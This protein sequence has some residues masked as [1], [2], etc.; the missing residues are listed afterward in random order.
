MISVITPT[1]D[2]R[3]LRA[4]WESLRAQTLRDWEWVV[5]ANGVSVTD[6]MRQLDPDPRIR[7]C[8]GPAS[9]SIGAIKRAAFALGRGDVLVELD[10][11][12]RLAS[13]ALAEIVAAFASPDVDFV[14][15]NHAD[16]LDDGS[17]FRYPGGDN[18]GY[19]ES[20]VDGRPVLECLARK[21]C[22][23][24]LSLIFH[25]PNHVRAWRRAFYERI[26]GH[27]PKMAI[28]D[29]HELLIR[30]YLHGRMR[31]IDKCLYLYRMSAA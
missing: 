5:Y 3:H 19:R 21:P 6:V 15:S 29:D 26:G 14:Y 30:T 27:D 16:V 9:D 12:D 28:C 20:I 10:H 2:P 17:C 4:T 1:H 8:S 18:W 22:A 25:A 11:D 13:T 24:S 23:A 31:H 7:I